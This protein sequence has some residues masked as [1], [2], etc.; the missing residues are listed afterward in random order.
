MCDYSLQ[1]WQ[2]LSD[3]YPTTEIK[4]LKNGFH[5]PEVRTKCEYKLL[6]TRKA[7]AWRAFK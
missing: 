3:H 6:Q 4:S 5:S 2:S 1:N 7:R